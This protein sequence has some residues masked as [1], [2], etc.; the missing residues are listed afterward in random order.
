[1][2]APLSRLLVY[3]GT[4]AIGEVEDHGDRRIIAFQLTPSGRVKIGQFPDRRS[5]MRAIEIHS[6]VPPEPA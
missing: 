2:T 5:A 3:D 6:P 4:I 1:M